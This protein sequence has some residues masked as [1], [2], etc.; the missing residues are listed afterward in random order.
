VQEPIGRRT[1]WYSR[2]EERWDAIAERLRALRP[3]LERPGVT[4]WVLGPLKSALHVGKE[5]DDRGVCT[6][7]T[8]VALVNAVL[9]GLPGKMGVGVVVSEVLEVW[10]A[11]TIAK[12]VGLAVS[13]PRD[14]LKYMTMA[15]A[16]LAVVFAAFRQLL[17]LAFSAFAVVPGLNPMIPAELLVTNLVGIIFWVGFEEAAQRGSFLV[18]KRLWGSI[19]LRTRRLTALQWSIVKTLFS[20]GTIDGVYRRVRAFIAG[21]VRVKTPVLSPDVLTAHYALAMIDRQ[22]DA[23]GGPVFDEFVASIRDLYPDLATASVDEI[24]DTLR[25]YNDEQLTGALANIKG[26][27]FERL[28][29]AAENQDEDAWVA[30]LHADRR[31]PGTDMVIRNTDTGEELAVSLKATDNPS[32]VLDSLDRYPDDPVLVTSE[33][34]ES[35]TGDGRIWASD[36]SNAYLT[37]VTQDNFDAVLDEV[38]GSWPGAIGA[39]TGISTLAALWPFVAAY[40]RRSISKADLTTAFTRCLGEGAAGF[41]GRVALQA[42]TGPLYA[43]IALARGVMAIASAL[44]VEDGPASG[45]EG[46]PTAERHHGEP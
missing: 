39:A 19:A 13:S 24:A 43:W 38:S 36:L 22:N 35:L 6:T 21:E 18:P 7:I 32:Y 25:V 11:Y 17:G 27:L 33:V 4:E 14:V 12:R 42:A 9:A 1:E 15:V 45:S 16:T 10:M 44:P 40:L 23:L 46:G 31:H 37:D 34:G 8:K 20:R 2:I 5:V 3:M 26:R 41:A 28:S 30:V 29:E